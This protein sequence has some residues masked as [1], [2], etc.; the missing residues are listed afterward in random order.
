MSHRLVIS[1]SLKQALAF[2]LFNI[3]SLAALLENKVILYQAE[4]ISTLT[5]LFLVQ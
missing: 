3:V 4:V 1:Y 2:L 5:V